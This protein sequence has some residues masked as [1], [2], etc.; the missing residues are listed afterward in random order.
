MTY[1][2]ICNKASRHFRKCI[3]N[4]NIRSDYLQKHSTK[5]V[6]SWV[7]VATQTKNERATLT[8]IRSFLLVE[9][10]PSNSLF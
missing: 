5:V 10:N 8:V 3:I 2:T 6:A 9:G 7:C 1:L 4:I